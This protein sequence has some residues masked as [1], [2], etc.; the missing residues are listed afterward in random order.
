VQELIFTLAAALTRDY[1]RQPTCTV[2]THA[3]FPQVLGIVQRYIEKKV[4]PVSPAETVDVFLSP[5]YGWV[6]ER[7]NEAIRPDTSQGEAPEVPRY[8]SSRGPGS[9]AD[10]DFTTSRD[11]REVVHSHLNYIV[12]DTQKWEQSAAFYIDRHPAV[13]AFVKN[14]GLGFAIPYLHNGQ[15]HDYVPDFIVRLKTRPQVHLILETKGYDPLQDVKVEAAQRWVAAV[16][17]DGT[18]GEWKY[19]IAKKPADVDPVLKSFTLASI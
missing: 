14:A 7:L 9:T 17:A 1:A 4:Q 13:A 8:E 12:A 19:A 16:N 15:M 11:V 5:Y 18:Y 3:L 10:V 6:I 2:P